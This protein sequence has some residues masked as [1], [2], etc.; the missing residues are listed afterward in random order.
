MKKLL[1]SSLVFLAVIAFGQTAKQEKLLQYVNPLVGSDSRFDFSNGNTY[2]AIALPWGMNFWT[3]QTNKMGDGWCYQYA[4]NKIRGFKQTHQPSPWIND[5]GAFSIFATTEKLVFDENKRE[6]WFSHK[7]EVSKPNYY[8]AY[9]SDYNTTVEITPTERAA[10]FRITYP[11]TDKAY[12]IIDGFF[13][14]SMVKVFPKE[15]KI[16]GYARNSSGGV[17][18]NF[19]NYFVIYVDKEFEEIFGVKDGDIQVNVSEVESKHA[20]SIIRFKTKTNEQV[21]LKIASSFISAEQAELNLQSEIGNQTFDQLVEKGANSWNTQLNRIKVEGGSVDEMRTFYTALYHTMLFPRKF[22]EIGKDN[23]IVHY[24]PYNGKVES[25][26]MFTDNGFWDTFR[27]VFP[28]FNLMYPEMNNQIMEGLANTYKEGG[29]LPEWASPGH[30]DCMVGSNS[31][32]IISDAYLKGVGKSNIETLYE[33]ITKNTKNEGPLSS[34]GRLGA[35]YYNDL[36]YVPY[37]VGINENTARTL[38][39]AYDDF[40]IWKLAKSLNKPQSEIDLYAKRAQNYRNVFDKSINFVRGKN[41]DGSFQSPFRPDKW[42]DA[43]TEGCSWHWTW[44]V[45]HDVQGLVDL[46]GG[47]KNFVSKLDSVFSSPP[48]FDYSYY[49]IQIHEITEMLVMNMGQYAHGNQPIQHMPY[50]YNYAGEPWKTQYHVRNIM[51]KLYS[52]NPDGLCGDEDNGQTS[53]WYVFSALGMY[54]VA[55]AT[56]QY[57]LGSPL[58]KK[59]T[60]SLQNGKTFTIV[61]PENNANNVYVSGAKLNNV[62]YSKNF[63]NY[64]D[65]MKGGTLNLMM[66][67]KPNKTKGI[68]DSDF[69]Y[70]MTNELKK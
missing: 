33:A 65:V 45:F 47:K 60:I 21:N 18:D 57:V 2:P 67:S 43:F 14:N 4:S 16:V 10:R 19:K 24:S 46:M 41:K 68:A 55:P 59:A 36:G 27:A 48:T 63:L 53:A 35:K 1:T 40:T 34:V 66:S 20:G 56:D 62:G 64:N 44:C 49:G 28:L 13:K 54:P 61:A 52:A 17:P 30:R 9:L 38:E 3:P 7:A 32:S 39:Y 23:K 37:D 25:G 11:Q 8:K 58:F 50:L 22:Y 5:Y 6:S 51:K 70:S 29:W 26:Y 69:P 15:R 12:L 31:A 42:G